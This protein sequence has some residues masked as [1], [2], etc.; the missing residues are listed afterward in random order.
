MA[1]SQL[2][3][4][5]YQIRTR[6]AELIEVGPNVPANAVRAFRQ[7]LGGR[8]LE[9]PYLCEPSWTVHTRYGLRH[10]GPG[11]AL[12]TRSA[13]ALKRMTW[14]PGVTPVP[15]ETRRLVASPM[16]HGL[17]VIDE[18]G[19]IR[20]TYVT[21]PTGPLPSTAALLAVLDALPS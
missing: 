11:R 4:G 8:E 17:F 3:G 13:S 5:Y 18:E 19:V 10:V 2:R 21:T 7:D 14:Q 6:N 20:Y 9:F 15:I 1:L 16:Q 12:K